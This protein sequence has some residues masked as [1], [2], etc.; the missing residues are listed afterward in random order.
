MSECKYRKVA[1][2]AAVRRSISLDWHKLI[3]TIG[4]TPHHTTPTG[5][6]TAWGKV[7]I[8]STQQ[9]QTNCCYHRYSTSLSYFLIFYFF[10]PKFVLAFLGE[11]KCERLETITTDLYYIIQ[12]PYHLFESYGHHAAANKLVNIPTT[13]SSAIAERPRCRV[14]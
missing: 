10:P 7:L 6:H 11:N 4:T 8:V 5:Y 1:S 9:T 2:A 12:I 3:S 14:G 13:S